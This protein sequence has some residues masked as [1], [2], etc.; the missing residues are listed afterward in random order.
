MKNN[1]VFL[2]LLAC[3]I[4]TTNSNAASLWDNN[5]VFNNVTSSRVVVDPISGGTFMSGGA[6]EVRFKTNGNY[7]PAF[8]F[9]APGLKANCSGITFDAGYA[10]FM[11]LERLGQQ[12]SQAGAS[13]AYGVLIGLVYTMPGVEQAFSKLNEWSQWLQSFLADSC[14][15]GTQ[16]GKKLGN[17]AW[18]DIEG[19]KNS[20]TGD[21]P[22][23]SEYLDKPTAVSTFLKKIINEG[24]DVQQGKAFNSVVNEMF[25]DVKGGAVATYINSL[26]KRGE[27]NIKFSTTEIMEFKDLDSI[28][29]TDS[30][31]IM[32]YLISSIINSDIAIDEKIMSSVIGDI[33]GKNAEKLAEKMEEKGGKEKTASSIQARNKL[34]PEAIIKFLLLGKQNGEGGPLENIKGLRVGLASIKSDG[35]VKEEFVLLSSE[36]S[37]NNTNAFDSFEGYIQES[38]KLVFRT[39]NQS[40]INLKGVTKTNPITDT[41]KVT[42]AYPVMY[43]IIR[44]LVL[45][46]N[47]RDLL[48][49]NSKEGTDVSDVLNYVAYKNAIALA[50]MAIDNMEFAIKKSMTEIESKKQDLATANPTAN[51][52]FNEKENIENIKNQIKEVDK[53]IELLKAGL[54]EYALKVESMNGITQLNERLNKILKERNIQ[55][56]D[57]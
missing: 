37:A 15:I 3:T 5:S 11:N 1:K 35:G 53:Q 27:E 47:K 44:N 4:L 36:T 49:V 32:S 20:I 12:L 23:P 16:I 40:M 25:K 48:D 54:K 52:V 8:N 17:S 13:L 26:V 7:P 21:I 6:I 45:T 30:T 2:S 56:G 50:G 22:S 24:T 19:A 57:K 33:K 55:K 10:I 29:L 42:S 31:K 39:Y 46:T 38:K 43:E 51:G 9:G 18:R 34:S 41:P 14:N 28:G